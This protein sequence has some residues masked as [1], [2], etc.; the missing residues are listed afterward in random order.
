MRAESDDHQLVSACLGIGIAGVHNLDSPG[1]IPAEVVVSSKVQVQ[2]N[3]YVQHL[4][5][6]FPSSSSL[7]STRTW[8]SALK[9]TLL[10]PSPKELDLGQAPGS[11]R[12]SASDQRAQRPS[13]GHKRSPTLEER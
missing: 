9:S 13:S 1:G 5:G 2:G 8:D 3:C 10:W 11:V 6:T 7:T 12:Y 4:L